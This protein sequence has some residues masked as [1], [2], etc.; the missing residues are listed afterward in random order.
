MKK[1]V[2]LLIFSVMQAFYISAATV[3]VIPFAFDD[4]ESDARKGWKILFGFNPQNDSWQFFTASGPEKTETLINRALSEGTN[5]LYSPINLLETTGLPC[6]NSSEC[7]VAWVNFIP[8]KE[9]FQ[10]GRNT[11]LN[12]FAWITAHELSD[13]IKKNPPQLSP[14]LLGA[15]TTLKNKP[16][17]KESIDIF[18]LLNTHKKFLE[19]FQKNLLTTLSQHQPKNPQQ[20]IIVNIAKQFM[21]NE[22]WGAD[23]NYNKTLKDPSAQNTKKRAQEIIAPNTLFFSQADQGLFEL[24][25]YYKKT[26]YLFILSPYDTT[27][28][29][30]QKPYSWTTTEH[31]FQAQKATNP[32]DF[33][34]IQKSNDPNF[35]REY[36]DPK[37]GRSA[38]SDWH[39]I[40]RWPFYD[41]K[42]DIMLTALRAKFLQN[43]DLQKLLLATGN[44]ILVED[45][46]Q[47]NYED[48]FWGNGH[49]GMG[50]NHLGQLL[51][52]VRDEIRQT[53]KKFGTATEN[54][55]I[56]K[57][58]DPHPP[59]W[60]HTKT[61]TDA[62]E[63]LSSKLAVL[64]SIV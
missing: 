37:Y 49:S 44:K 58:Y 17:K 8:G 35:A 4:A 2:H 38:R 12:D 40:I 18:R 55:L 13:I 33:N 23:N 60:Y 19:V 54:N 61:Y 26:P 11:Q 42:L 5:N 64:S 21:N 14:A 45:T 46:A 22:N 20:K 32:A 1:R 10:K 34:A 57:E 3:H 7:F 62:L 16:F 48:Y 50:W 47:A 59:S 56:R 29:V 15:S 30:T 41:K 36:W 6:S 53:I 52:H 27:S 31:Y 39:T 24:T 9:L 25:N 43:A 51:M 28:G 63:D